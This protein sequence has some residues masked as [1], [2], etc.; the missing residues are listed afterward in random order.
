MQT[1]CE[2]IVIDYS[3]RELCYRPYQN[4]P[5][6]CP[7]FGKRPTCPPRCLKLENAFDVPK[8]FWV[9]WVDFDFAIYRRNMKRKHPNWS[10]RQI[11]CCLYWQ[12]G[13]KKKLKEAVVDLMYY[14]DGRGDW[15]ATDCPEAFGVNVTETMKTLGVILEW[16]PENIVYKIAIIGIQRGQRN[17]V[18]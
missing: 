7:N 11:D 3:V 10:Q 1:F 15:Y 16:P 6:G 12:G 18:R 17:I 9:V 14:L 4:H 5:K 8:G 2:K 13:V